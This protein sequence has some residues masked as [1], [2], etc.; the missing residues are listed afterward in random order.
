MAYVGFEEVIVGIFDDAGE[1][2]KELFTWK[3]EKGGTVNL[4]I[5][6]LE[7]EISE[8]WAS[9]KRVW[10]SKRGTGAVTSSFESFNPPQ[11]DLDKVLGRDIDTNGT[12]WAGSDTNPPYVAMIAKS[13]DIDGEPVYLALVK[14]MFGQNEENL[15]TNTNESTTPGNTTLTGSWQNKDIEGKSRVYGKH[16]G[17]EGYDAF[18]ALVFPDATVDAEA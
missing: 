2:I 18:Y 1:K 8:V 4:N 12:S 7:K 9:D 14:G 3:D 10:M 6:G 17:E 13:H 5:T 15:A 16:I 11:A